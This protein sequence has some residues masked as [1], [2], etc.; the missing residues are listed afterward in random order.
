M[1]KSLFIFRRD[2]RLYDNTSLIECC[3]KSDV[4]HCIF[5]M[6][7]EQLKHNSYKS[8]S[9]IQFMHESLHDLNIQLNNKLSFFYGN[10]SDIIKKIIPGNY[11]NLYVTTDY[12]YYSKL[13]DDNIRK[14]CKKYNIK[15]FS[16][17]D[18]MLN[19]YNSVKNLIVLN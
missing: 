12:T 2:L 11:D 18:H 3:K 14:I 17:E 10:T 19:N 16:I 1:I 8:D 6:T 9:S 5:I 4:V 15:F 13:R 7:P